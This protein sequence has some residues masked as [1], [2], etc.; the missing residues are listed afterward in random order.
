M[1]VVSNFRAAMHA[2]S[3][4]TGRPGHV[5]LSGTWLDAGIGQPSDL[6]AGAKPG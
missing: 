4:E 5:C 6:T 1:T 3:Y 2:P